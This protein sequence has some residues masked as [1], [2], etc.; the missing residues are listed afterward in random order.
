MPRRLRREPLT[1]EEVERLVSA[2]RTARD[3]RVV[4]T[5]LD[6][7]LRVS[8]LAS[9]TRRNLDARNR[10]LRIT[11]RDTEDTARAQDRVIPLAPRTLQV[12]DGYFQKR[13]AFDTGPRTIQRIIRAVAARAGMCCAVSPA[14]LRHT[15]AST[16]LKAGMSAVALQCILGLDHLSALDAFLNF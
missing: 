7:G 13:D 9:L 4:L 8:E 3:K 16:A 1:L 12:L 10:S 5:L 2:C 14:V 11:G 6:T 15:F